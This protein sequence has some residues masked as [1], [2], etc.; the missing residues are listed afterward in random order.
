MKEILLECMKAIARIPVKVV[1]VAATLV[2]GIL[3]FA[4]EKILLCLRVQE[5]RQSNGMIL[6]IILLASSVLL[7]LFLIVWGWRCFRSLT[8][9]SGRDAKRRLDALGEWDKEL[10]YRLYKTPSHAAKLPLQ[11]AN[12]VAL[13]AQNILGKALLGDQAG[14]ECVLQPW[15]LRYLDKHPKYRDSIEKKSKSRS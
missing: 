14:F 13:L 6:G 1:L 12:V 7:F 4:P 2:S 9:Y 15:V 10:V 11:S 3:L 8:M 5:V